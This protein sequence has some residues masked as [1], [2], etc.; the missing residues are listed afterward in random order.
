[1][2][3]HPIILAA[4]RGTRMKSDTPKALISFRNEPIIF[5]VLKAVADAFPRVTPTIVVGHEAKRV[6]DAIGNNVYFVH[7]DE[8]RGT[9]H[10]VGV[11]L[12]HV[13][14]TA[15][16][17]MVLYADHPLLS[18]ETI[19]QITKVHKK[20]KPAITMGTVTLDDFNDFRKN[21]E[22]FGRILRDTKGDIL[23][24]REWKDASD[25]ERLIKEVSPSYFC[26]EKT[27]L[28]DALKR[29]KD[30]NAA[31]EYYLTDV[32]GEAV[33]TKKRIETVSVGPREAIGVN[34]KEE[35]ALA[36]VLAGK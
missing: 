11:A 1:M 12:P 22:R 15:E 2:S 13:P 3:V 7:Q 29:I 20:K 35:L 26:F 18:K 16:H 36:E 24:I 28:T 33:R 5:R 6:M 25:E 10:A 9:G 32:V 31:H 27:W 30:T 4:G 19:V 8:Q 21:F 17:I 23:G 14:E 34:T